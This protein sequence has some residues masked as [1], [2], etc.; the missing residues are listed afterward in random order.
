MAQ[1]YQSKTVTYDNF[2]LK[3]NNFDTANYPLLFTKVELRTKR[4][5]AYVT[6][7]KVTYTT[8][9]EA[10]ENLLKIIAIHLTQFSQFSSPRMRWVRPG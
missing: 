9:S 4:L 8:H 6:M 2:V 5:A 7:Q 10:L 3:A 1:F